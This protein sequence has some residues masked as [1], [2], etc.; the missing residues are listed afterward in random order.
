M[1]IHNIRI[2]CILSKQKKINIY[3]YTSILRRLNVFNL[4][5]L[6]SDLKLCIYSFDKFKE[7]K[8]FTNSKLI[9]YWRVVVYVISNIMDF[10][11]TYRL[12]ILILHILQ[13]YLYI[14]LYTILQL[15]NS[16]IRELN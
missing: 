11:C 1:H 5:W 15:L 14:Y 8:L 4:Q 7:T 3:I 9:M 12:G 2:F 6:L 13:I 10:Y 16:F